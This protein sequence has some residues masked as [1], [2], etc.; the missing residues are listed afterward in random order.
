MIFGISSGAMKTATPLPPT[1][2][3]VREPLLH[4]KTTPVVRGRRGL[5]PPRTE[6]LVKPLAAPPHD[7]CA[8]SPL[9]FGIATF[10]VSLLSRIDHQGKTNYW[11]AATASISE[12]HGSGG[13]TLAP[14]RVL[15]DRGRCFAPS[16]EYQTAFWR[17]G[18]IRTNFLR[19]ARD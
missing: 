8:L 1:R 5:C 13:S 7:R 15:M 14:E 3:R 2:R 12:D 10:S 19:H 4:R 9:Y 18:A 17:W 16:Q 11:A 6:P